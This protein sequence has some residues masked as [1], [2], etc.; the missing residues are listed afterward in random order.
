MEEGRAS[1]LPLVRKDEGRSGGW[2]TQDY[3]T[4]ECEA[5]LIIRLKNRE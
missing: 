1:A 2:E 3:F 5:T 4:E